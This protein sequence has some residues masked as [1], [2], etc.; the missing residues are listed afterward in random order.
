[1]LGHRP[2][3][4]IEYRVIKCLMLCT[5][6][7]LLR[8]IGSTERT[9]YLL[10]KKRVP[11]SENKCYSRTLNLI[12]IYHFH[13]SKFVALSRNINSYLFIQSFNQKNYL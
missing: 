2:Y 7:E 5:G 12:I 9:A 13:Y 1:M 11:I 3:L 8:M 4:R 6:A 10:T